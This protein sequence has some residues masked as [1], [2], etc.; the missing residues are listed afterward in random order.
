MGQDELDRVRRDLETVKSAIGDELPF[1]RRQIGF[2][3]F[4]AVWGLIAAVAM[5][6]APPAFFKAA[7]AMLYGALLVVPLLW[8]WRMHRRGDK[9]IA[10]SLQEAWPILLAL[11]TG[12]LLI[13]FMMWQLG[14]PR[15]T[16]GPVVCVAIG[17]TILV[18]AVLHRRRYHLAGIGVMFVLM[19]VYIVLAPSPRSLVALF[20]LAIAAGSAVTAAIQI[21]QLLVHRS[22][23]AAD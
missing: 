1:D 20:C 4:F 2:S 21:C 23:H 6:L 16:A 13:G 19:G 9:L 5:G 3:L 17:L 18:V 7:S 15:A 22:K 8:R 12:W 10:S 14:L 11:V